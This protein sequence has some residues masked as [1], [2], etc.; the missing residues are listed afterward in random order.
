MELTIEEIE[1]LLMT[2]GYE[3]EVRQWSQSGVYA[4]LIHDIKEEIHCPCYHDTVDAACQC[5]WEAYLGETDD[6]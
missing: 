1:T 2:A 5:I 4:V 6:R 3:L